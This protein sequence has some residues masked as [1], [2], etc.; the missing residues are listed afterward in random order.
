MTRSTGGGDSERTYRLLSQLFQLII[1]FAYHQDRINETVLLDLE[2]KKKRDD[3]V[4]KRTKANQW[5]VSEQH[6]LDQSVRHAS[7][8][9]DSSVGKFLIVC[10]K[11]LQRDEEDAAWARSEVASLVHTRDTFNALLDELLT[12]LN[13]LDRRHVADVGYLV[14]RLVGTNQFYERRRRIA[15]EQALLSGSKVLF[16][17][18][19]YTLFFS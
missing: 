10:L 2:R 19:H 5:G 15:E 11:C 14:F 12:S 17:C 18:S 16:T 4:G 13:E 9:L 1:G 3:A 8:P 7:I 6:G